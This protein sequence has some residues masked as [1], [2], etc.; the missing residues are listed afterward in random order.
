TV[1]AQ[2]ERLREQTAQ[3][4]AAWQESLRQGRE[5][6]EACRRREA[7]AEKNWMTLRMAEEGLAQRC[8]LLEELAARYEGYG[9]GVQV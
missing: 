3:E 4:E 8:K 9:K 2:E 1:R 6:L 7:A 5:T